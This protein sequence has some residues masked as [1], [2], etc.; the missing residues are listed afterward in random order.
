[1]RSKNIPVEV[2]EIKDTIIAF[3]W[4]PVGHRFAVIH[5]STP[6][7]QRP[8]F[9]FGMTFLIYLTYFIQMSHFMKLS[10]MAWSFWRFYLIF[11]L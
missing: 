3:A 4:E 6:G 9:F 2:L 10:L 5:S 8:G 7:N 11:F 1:M